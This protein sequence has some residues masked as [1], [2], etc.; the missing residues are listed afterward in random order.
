[1]YLYGTFDTFAN[2][3]DLE[4]VHEMARKGF[5][6]AAIE[7]PNGHLCPNICQEDGHVCPSH[8]GKTPLIEK[9]RNIS[10]RLFPRYVP[11]HLKREF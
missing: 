3:P 8:F 7:Y 1:M 2:P 5:V 10:V 9:A 6:S 11:L 4:F